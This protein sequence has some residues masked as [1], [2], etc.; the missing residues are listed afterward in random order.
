MNTQYKELNGTSYNIKTS[1]SICQLLEKLRQD[2]TRVCFH[3]G[4]TKTGEDWADVY[5]VTGTIGRSNGTIK[6]PLLIQTARSLGGG[7]ILD[8]C[9]VKI[10]LSTKPHTILYK[11]PYY[12][13]KEENK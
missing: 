2:H 13:I 6:I 1:D 3:W 5:D 7:A 4:N 11:H 9:I 10:E 8:H 12:F